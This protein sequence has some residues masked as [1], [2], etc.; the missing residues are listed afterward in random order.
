MSA[1]S[2]TSEWVKWGVG[3]AIV[4]GGGAFGSSLRLEN[5]MTTVEKDASAVRIDLDKHIV[6][7]KEVKA[8]V[9]GRLKTVEAGNQQVLEKLG[10]VK[11]DVAAIRGALNIPKAARQ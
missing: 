10:E 1:Q 3:I 9:Y 11:E 7:S 2:T 4:L 5:R 6:D 8:D